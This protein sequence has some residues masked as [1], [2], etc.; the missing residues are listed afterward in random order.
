MD[1]IDKSKIAIL[2]TVTNFE[3]YKRTSTIFPEEI[4]KIVIDG[5]NGSM[6]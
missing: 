6:V 4:D 5:T 1:T 3:L 2:T